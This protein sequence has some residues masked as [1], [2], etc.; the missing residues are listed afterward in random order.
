MP[1]LNASELQALTARLPHWV[2]SAVELQRTV[3]LPTWADGLRA[4]QAL[5]EMADRHNHHPQLQLQ[6]GRLTLR[7]STHDVGGVTE[8]DAQAA[9]R[10]DALLQHLLMAPQHGAAAT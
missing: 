8:L 2:V 5:G 3:T 4:V 10:S 1:R 9:E 7:W 6:W